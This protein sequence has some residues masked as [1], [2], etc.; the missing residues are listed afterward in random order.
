MRQPAQQTGK[1]A[2]V[3]AL[4][5]TCIDDLLRQL[6]VVRGNVAQTP[7]SCLLDSRIELLQ[8]GHQAVQGAGIDHGLRAPQ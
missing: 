1:P 8:A 3:H 5:H 4:R 6:R 2:S 7:P